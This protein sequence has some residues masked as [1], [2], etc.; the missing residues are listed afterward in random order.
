MG[1]D[2]PTDWEQYQQLTDLYKYYLDLAV[3]STS[4]FWLITGGVLTFAFANSDNGSARWALLV[5]IA[6]GV[7][8]AG[9]MA[10]LKRHSDELD[11]SMRTLAERLG[12][13][14]RAHSEILPTT[15][16]WLGWLFLAIAVLVLVLLAA[17]G[18]F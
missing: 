9:S 3:K 14:Q 7:V 11:D 10:R 6:M 18:L 15:I 16:Y 5:P 17:F 13:T 8:L 4:I 1:G 12:L 2:G